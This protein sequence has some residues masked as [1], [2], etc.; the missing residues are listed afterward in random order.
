MTENRTARLGVLGGMGP[1]SSAEFVRS[2]YDHCSGVREQEF[3]GLALHSDPST[4]RRTPQT[5]DGQDSAVLDALIASLRS[6]TDLGCQEI[7][8]CCMTLHHLLPRV[9][10]D[11]SAAVVSVLD[12]AVEAIAR[13]PGRHLI[14]C[15]EDSRLLRLFEQHPGWDRVADSVVFAAPAWEHDLQRA[16][17]AIKVNR[18][19]GPALEWIARRIVETGATSVV[20]GC[21]EIHVLARRWGNRLTVPVL[22]PFDILAR[23]AAAGGFSRHAQI[24]TGVG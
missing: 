6:L 21:S 23:A 20:A 2:V 24:G 5:M 16:I 11:L 10:R 7:V 1:V 22:D 15:P 3:P 4:D 18:G 17:N 13:T 19:P 14:L 8:I 9:P 12:A